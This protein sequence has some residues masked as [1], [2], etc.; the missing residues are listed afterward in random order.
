[1]LAKGNNESTL[2][3]SKLGS[4]TVRTGTKY[5]QIYRCKK[6][7]I[8][9]KPLPLLHYSQLALRCPTVI[10]VFEKVAIYGRTTGRRRIFVSY[11]LQNVNIKLHCMKEYRDQTNNEE[12]LGARSSER[13]ASGNI[14]MEY[15]VEESDTL[16]DIGRKHNLSWD[17]IAE[18]NKDVLDDP[19]FVK[20]GFKLKI[21]NIRKF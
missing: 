16:E 15:T 5:S 4:T 10:W 2:E 13:S 1:L 9:L 21:P 19:D 17:Q 8:L 6:G 14:F 20:P 3:N 7:F 18:A 12:A 11:H